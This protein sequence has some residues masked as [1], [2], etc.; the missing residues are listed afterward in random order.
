MDPVVLKNVDGDMSK[1]LTKEL[2]AAEGYA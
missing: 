2:C 1:V